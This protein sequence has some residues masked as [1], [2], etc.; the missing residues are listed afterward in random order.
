MVNLRNIPYS[1]LSRYIYLIAADC[2]YLLV[3][4]KCWLLLGYISHN[5]QA[6]LSQ[7]MCKYTIYESIH[8]RWCGLM[9]RDGVTAAELVGWWLWFINRIKGCAAI[10]VGLV[11]M[12]RMNCIYADTCEASFKIVLNNDWNSGK[13]AMM[14]CVRLMA[15]YAY[16]A[17]ITS[18]LWFV[19]ENEKQKRIQLQRHRKTLYRNKNQCQVALLP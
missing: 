13:C 5:T 14:C 17:D 6:V 8:A 16:W 7:T 4:C 9:V 2:W 15:S 3:L 18:Y 12:I 10:C 11:Y 19:F 1:M